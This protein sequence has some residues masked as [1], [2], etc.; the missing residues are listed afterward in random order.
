MPVAYIQGSVQY[1]PRKINTSVRR[2][3]LVAEVQGGY[4]KR[5]GCTYQLLTL[6]CVVG[7]V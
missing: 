6:A 1:R 4:R 3:Y 7:T 2:R 5:R